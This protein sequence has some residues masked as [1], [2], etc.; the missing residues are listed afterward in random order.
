MDVL[1]KGIEFE[2]L[3][4]GKLM[5]F[6]NGNKKTQIV[7]CK[8]FHGQKHVIHS[9]HQTLKAFRNKENISKTEEIEFLVRLSGEGQIKVA[10]ER[11]RPGKKSVFVSWGKNSAAVFGALKKMGAREY[12]LKEPA[13]EDVKN[14]I[15]R[16]ATFYLS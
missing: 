2:K 16:T 12:A 7:N 5:D 9:V 1:V 3:D 4:F 13:L 8:C 14:A 6:L 10:L 15:E 11:C